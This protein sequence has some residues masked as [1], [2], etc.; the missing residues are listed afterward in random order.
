M[1][2]HGNIIQ[3]EIQ[4]GYQGSLITRNCLTGV[5]YSSVSP[6]YPA[7]HLIYYTAMARQ[8]LDLSKFISI[9]DVPRDRK[10]HFL[11]ER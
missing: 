10:K 1:S 4:E 9:L 3:Y 7:F 11:S 6:N 2:R 8:F 5:V